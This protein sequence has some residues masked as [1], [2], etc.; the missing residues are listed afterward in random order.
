MD[1]LVAAARVLVFADK[2]VTEAEQRL[3]ELKE[4]ARVLREE[5][6]PNAMLELGLKRI[7]LETGESLQM[8]LEVYASIPKHAKEAAFAWLVQHHFD[9]IIKTEVSVEFGKGHFKQALALQVALKKKKLDATCEQGIHH[10]T[11]KAFLK[12]Q[13]AAGTDIP[14]DLFGAWPVFTTKLTTKETR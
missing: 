6:L 3:A 4:R 13:M 2:A 7:E 5:T 12:E 8:K 9:G 11:L 1:A 14:L 10:S